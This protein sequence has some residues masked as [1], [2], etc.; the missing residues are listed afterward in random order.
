MIIKI[1][2]IIMA[3]CQFRAFPNVGRTVKPSSDKKLKFGPYCVPNRRE[4]EIT[5]T[6]KP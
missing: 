5:A 6:K 2:D 4:M 1:R 3:V